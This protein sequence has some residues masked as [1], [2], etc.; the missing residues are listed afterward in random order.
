MVFFPDDIKSTS[1]TAKHIYSSN[2]P[3]S[4]LYKLEGT[5]D[6]FEGAIRI[7]SRQNIQQRGWVTFKTSATVGASWFS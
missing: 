4:L 6:K 3:Q 7:G 1:Y 5:K 2:Y